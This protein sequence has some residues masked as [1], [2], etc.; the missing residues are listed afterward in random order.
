MCKSRNGESGNKMREMM[1]MR[2]IRLGMMGMWAI[3]MGLMGIRVGMQMM[4]MCRIS[5]GM[6]G[7]R[8]GMQGTGGRNEGNKGDN[9][10]IGVELMNYNCGEG[11]ETK[12]CV[13]L[14]IA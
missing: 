6:Q 12:N 4:R 5:V 13:F 9:L 3:R 8:V 14:G 7:I 11:Q 10:C 2:V 1:G